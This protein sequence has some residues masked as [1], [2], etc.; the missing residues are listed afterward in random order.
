MRKYEERFTE[1]LIMNLQKCQD[2]GKQRKPKKLSWT[3]GDVR[4]K[5]T[6]TS[7]ILEER[8]KKKDISEK[9]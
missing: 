1:Y 9:W 3:K 5:C 8:K 2:H 4:A 7:W 6:M